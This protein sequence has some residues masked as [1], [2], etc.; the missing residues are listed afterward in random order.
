MMTLDYSAVGPAKLH[1]IPLMLRHR[2]TADGD[3]GAFGLEFPGN[4][5][6][7]YSTDMT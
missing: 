6:I 3:A 7:R 2:E 5:V 1:E 4:D